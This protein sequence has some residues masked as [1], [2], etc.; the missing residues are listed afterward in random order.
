MKFLIGHD[1]KQE[2]NT[3]LELCSNSM[4]YIQT[5]HSLFFSNLMYIYMYL[6]VLEKVN[7][8]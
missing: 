5:K 8:I 7:A 6:Y 4:Y 3:G 1:Q 2:I